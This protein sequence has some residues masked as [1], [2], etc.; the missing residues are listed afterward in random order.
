[1]KLQTSIW[2]KRIV[3]KQQGLKTNQIV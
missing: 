3:D 2:I 1:M